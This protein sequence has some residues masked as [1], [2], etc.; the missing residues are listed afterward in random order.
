MTMTSRERMLTALESGRPDRLPCQVHGWM[1]YY[2]DRYLDGADWWEAYA[3]FDMD[4]AMY[5]SPTY[6][7]D[8]GDLATWQ[9][10]RTDLG[11]DADGNRHWEET[12]TP[13]DMGGDCDLAAASQQVGDKLFFLG[14]FDQNAGFEHGTPADARCL[15]F[16]CFEA[17]KDRAGYVIAPSDHFFHGDPANLQAF[18]DAC[19]ECTY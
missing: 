4:Y 15:V 19:K 3:R 5:V 6:R 18:A 16:E 13:P 1:G 17:T 7:Y 11:V 9:V 8:Q 2:L 14:G 12:M 10:E